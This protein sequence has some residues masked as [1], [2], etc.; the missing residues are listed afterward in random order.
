MSYTMLW[1]QIKRILP[2]EKRKGSVARSG[3]ANRQKETSN[4][5]TY[6]FTRCK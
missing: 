2:R 4:N 6:T 3:L 5:T 1:E